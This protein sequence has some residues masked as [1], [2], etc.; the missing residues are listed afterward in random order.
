MSLYNYLTIPKYSRQQPASSWLFFLSTENL[1]IL[2]ILQPWAQL[3]L[4]ES[5]SLQLFVNLLFHASHSLDGRIE[6][7]NKV[8]QSF[9]IFTLVLLKDKQK[10]M[11]SG[12]RPTENNPQIVDLEFFY[13]N[14]F[15]SFPTVRP[16][17]FHKKGPETKDQLR[18]P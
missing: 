1:F 2:R 14:F 15:Y 16:T 3:L 7:G 4:L 8:I 17:F 10:N 18:S 9:F 13:E 12:N 6:D 11:N 5:W